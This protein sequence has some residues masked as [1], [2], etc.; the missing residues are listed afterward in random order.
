MGYNPY[1]T[2]AGVVEL[3]ITCN[4]MVWMRGGPSLFFIIIIIIFF[5]NNL[6]TYSK[7]LLTPNSINHK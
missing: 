4:N 7:Y 5:H 3:G 2:A 6:S 1:Q